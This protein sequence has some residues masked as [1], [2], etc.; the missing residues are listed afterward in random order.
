M[1]TDPLRDI[2]L[3]T[4]RKDDEHRLLRLSRKGDGKADL[5]LQAGDRIFIGRM[6]KLVAVTGEVKRPAVYELKPRKPPVTLSKWRS[7]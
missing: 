6:E 1:R 3:I 7:A 2:K 5:P 4:E